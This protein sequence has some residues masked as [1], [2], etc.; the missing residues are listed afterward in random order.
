MKVLK[1]AFLLAFCVVMSATAQTLTVDAEKVLCRV[2]PLIYGTGAERGEN[3]PQSPTGISPKAE[4]LGSEKE[5]TLKA[6]S[7][8]VVVI[9]KKH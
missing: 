3:T 2:E 5:V 4:P 8:T 1:I 9:T 7:Y 6:Y